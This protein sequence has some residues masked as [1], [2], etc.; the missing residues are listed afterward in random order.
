LHFLNR[1]P[2]GLQLSNDLAT[3]LT[4]SAINS[5]I[6]LYYNTNTHYKTWT[7]LSTLTGV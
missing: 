4:A 5:R 6:Q 1:Q 2:T 7:G 3:S